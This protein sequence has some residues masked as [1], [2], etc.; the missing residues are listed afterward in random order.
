MDELEGDRTEIISLLERF[1]APGR[2]KLCVS[3]RVWNVFERA[4]G[5]RCQQMRVE[6]LTRSDL[7]HYVHSR[8]RGDE[9]MSQILDKEQDTRTNWIEKLLDNAEGVFLWVKLVVGLLLKDS[10]NEPTLREVYR[11]VD[12]YPK[13]IDPLYERMLRAIDQ[14]PFVRDA[15]Q[16]LQL[17]LTLRVM[18][19]AGL[20]FFSL[21]REDPDYSLTRK[22]RPLAEEEL[23]QFQKIYSRLKGRCM[24][25]L[26]V[27]CI[28]A[29]SESPKRVLTGLE[30]ISFSHRTARDFF[31]QR[32]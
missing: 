30:E 28:D 18:T 7:R 2:G 9:F 20:W 26:E 14:S 4:Y 22:L 16:T 10:V 1:T 21:E 27:S 24:D 13:Q 29:Q 3:S 25:F 15:A 6:R 31:E 32:K 8:L 11:L 5:S 12:E 17:C 23:S 19:I